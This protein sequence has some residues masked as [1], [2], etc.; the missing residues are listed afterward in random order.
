MKK[1][2]YNCYRCYQYLQTVDKNFTLDNYRWLRDFI[3][4]L[5][6]KEYTKYNNRDLY[7]Q[8]KEILKSIADQIIKEHAEEIKIYKKQIEKNLIKTFNGFN[9]IMSYLNCQI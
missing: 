8:Q 4:K 7:L 2:W 9:E 1:Q 3:L 6:E 5:D